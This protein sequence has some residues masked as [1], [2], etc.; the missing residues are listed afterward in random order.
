M[1]A[2]PPKTLPRNTVK[3]TAVAACLENKRASDSWKTGEGLGR[4]RYLILMTAL[5]AGAPL[6]LGQP[7]WHAENLALLHGD[8]YRVVPEEQTTLTFEH[9]SGWTWG[10]LF[11][12]VD[13]THFHHAGV[14]TAV[15]SEWNPRVSLSWLSGQQL[16]AGPI[17]DVLIATTFEVGDGDVETLL[18]GPGT[19]WDLPG[20][21]FFNLNLQYAI[22]RYGDSHGWQVTAAWAWRSPVAG[23]TFVFEGYTDWIPASRGGYHRNLHFNPQLKMDLGPWLN[24]EPEHLYVGVEYDFWSH[25]FGIEDS[26]AFPTRQNTASIMIQWKF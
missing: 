23:S 18:I 24:T 20:F 4:L 2:R 15:Y 16:T 13:V 6:A 12:F 9:V 17:K 14:E 1:K 7:I 25:K 8:G 26:N 19:S 3:P 10:D 22:P 21:D 5:A 11:G